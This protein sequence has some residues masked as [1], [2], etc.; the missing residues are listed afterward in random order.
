VCDRYATRT[1]SKA[2]VKGSSVCGSFADA[3]GSDAQAEQPRQSQSRDWIVFSSIT[4]TMNATSLEQCSFV[5]P[6]TVAIFA[7]GLGNSEDSNA[8]AE[9]YAETEEDEYEDEDEYAA[10][11]AAPKVLFWIV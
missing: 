9:P 8:A 11:A 2:K 3:A 4:R 1:E 6:V 5:S 10:A 7:G